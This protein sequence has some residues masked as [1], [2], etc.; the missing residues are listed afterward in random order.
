MEIPKILIA[1]RAIASEYDHQLQVNL[2]K[3]SDTSINDIIVDLLS[4]VDKF[5]C[6][7]YRD[8]II[9]VINTKS[10]HEINIVDE[11]EIIDENLESIAQQYTGLIIAINNL[12]KSKDIIKFNKLMDKILFAKVI[13]R[14]SAVLLIKIIIDN[15]MVLLLH[16]NIELVS[17]STILAMELIMRCILECINIRS[18]SQL[19]LLHQHHTILYLLIIAN[20]KSLINCN[21]TIANTKSKHEELSELRKMN[22]KFKCEKIIE[23]IDTLL[24]LFDTTFH[25]L[26]NDFSSDTTIYF[27]SLCLSENCIELANKILTKLFYNL[28]EENIANILIAVGKFWHELENSSNVD[29]YVAH[30]INNIINM[31]S[32]TPKHNLSSASIAAILPISLRLCN[33]FSV[34]DQILGLNLLRRILEVLTSSTII[35]ISSWLLPQL[36][37]CL[38]SYTGKNISY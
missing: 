5:K 27:K 3:M 11:F 24:P 17:P 25:N 20:Q 16:P 7:D 28:D 32:K 18:P 33:R 9:N 22:N 37:I 19:S 15:F 6:S 36:L 2:L 14:D 29:I 31:I 23:K 34:N 30:I 10:E 1:D 26:F 35:S 38:K 21:F 4:I 8:N 13:Q 12:D